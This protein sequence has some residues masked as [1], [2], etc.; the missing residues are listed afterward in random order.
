[1][2]QFRLADFN[3]R[4][5]DFVVGPYRATRGRP[6]LSEGAQKR[7]DDFHDI[8]YRTLHSVGPEPSELSW[9]G[10]RTLKCPLDLI[11]YQE[12]I[13]ETRP[14][15][16]VEAGTKFGGSALFFASIC[17]LIGTGRVVTIDIDPQ[18]GL[19]NHALIS[20]IR[21][22][23]TDPEVVLR[24]KEMAGSSSVM[25]ILDS[26]HRKH[27]VDEELN[28]YSNICTI[29]Q[30]LIVE[31]SNINGHP[32]HPDYGPGPQEALQ[33]FLARDSRYSIDRNRERHLV[34]FAPNGFL[35]RIR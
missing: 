21:G 18:A 3:R 25:V 15:L 27:H 2:T 26:L 20:Y 35:R 32:V 8:Y 22:S 11:T 1:M 16:I 13:C 7:V 12:I 28:I 24:V 4:L 19:P 14:S 34:T 29:G 31:D 9:L 6:Q 10:Y 17:Q 5:F 23:S 30:Y 33:E